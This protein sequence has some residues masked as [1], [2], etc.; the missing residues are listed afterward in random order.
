MM[1]VANVIYVASGRTVIHDNEQHVFRINRCG[2]CGRRCRPGNVSRSAFFALFRARSIVCRPEKAVTLLCVDSPRHAAR[3]GSAGVAAVLRG[4]D[5][6]R[7][8][9]GLRVGKASVFQDVGAVAN[10]I[11]RVLDDLC[12]AHAQKC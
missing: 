10:T 11:S 4:G 7:V 6:E 1:D 12:A 2:R 5:V 3:I 8:N 9:D